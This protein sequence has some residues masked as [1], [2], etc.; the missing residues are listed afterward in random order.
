MGG[1]ANVLG[2]CIILEGIGAETSQ[3]LEFLW[4][5]SDVRRTPCNCDFT[6]LPLCKKT[7]SW[8]QFENTDAW[9]IRLGT[10]QATFSPM[11]LPKLLGVADIFPSGIAS[12]ACIPVVRHKAVAEVSEEETY[13]R[14][15]L[16]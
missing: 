10:T 6:K 8:G 13:R 12:T 7:T 4:A 9:E 15:W 11:E 1:C 2:T 16:L 5:K 14:G 3:D